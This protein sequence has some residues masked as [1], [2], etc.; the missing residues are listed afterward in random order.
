MKKLLLILFLLIPSLVF[1]NG[2]G[3]RIDYTNYCD[4]TNCTFCGRFNKDVGYVVDKS[5]NDNHGIIS[6][7]T[8][9]TTGKEGNS[10]AFDKVNDYI[11]IG[12]ASILDNLAPL[13]VVAW[14]YAIDEGENDLGY[15]TG[16]VGGTDGWSW[17][18]DGT[19]SEVYALMFYR[20]TTGAALFRTSAN[21]VV[22]Q[23]TWKHVAFT[24][25]GTVSDYT[26][27]KIYVDGTETAY[28]GGQ[29]NGTGGIGDD[30]GG[31]LC[32]GNRN[33]DTARTWNGRIDEVAIFNRVLTASEIKDIYT[34]GLK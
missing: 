30:D 4:D 3:L 25:D 22:V 9:N 23:N 19:G 20:L 24:W 32:I 34:Y 33:T 10:W 11:N 2:T 29:Q 8:Y 15:V 28:D 6:G 1:A 12:D 31:D 21:N 27:V 13:S 7:A 16:K 14:V 18:I 26:T 5:S 17:G